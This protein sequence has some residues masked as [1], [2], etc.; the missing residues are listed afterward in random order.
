MFQTHENWLKRQSWKPTYVYLFIYFC[1]STQ[2]KLIHTYILGWFYLSSTFHRNIEWPG[3]KRTKMIIDFQPP[4][5]V[6]GRQSRDQA[7]QSNIQPGLECLQGWGTHSLLGQPVQ[8]VTTLCVEKFLLKSS[9]NLP[10]HSLKPFSLVLSRFVCLGIWF[11]ISFLS[12]CTIYLPSVGDL[13]TS[14]IFSGGHHPEAGILGKNLAMITP[15]NSTE[16]CYS[17]I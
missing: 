11:S 15:T 16:N 3:L 13:G 12:S 4:C 2:K 17:W 9:L 14:S 10:Y 5:Y 6:Q 7:V 1:M 8:C